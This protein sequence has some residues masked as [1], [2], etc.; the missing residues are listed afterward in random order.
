MGFISSLI[1]YRQCGALLI[2]KGCHKHHGTRNF[3]SVFGHFAAKMALFAA[4]FTAQQNKIFNCIWFQKNSRLN[5]P[6]WSSTHHSIKDHTLPLLNLAP[7]KQ[8]I[9]SSARFLPKSNTRVLM[10][11]N[12]FPLKCCIWKIISNSLKLISKTN[13]YKWCS[14]KWIMSW[15][16]LLVENTD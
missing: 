16:L 11:M 13:F 15:L 14:W 12:L 10:Q 3:V 1:T 5:V 6:Y 8:L 4:C 9:P 7:C 2:S